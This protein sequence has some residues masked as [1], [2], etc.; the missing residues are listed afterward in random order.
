MVTAWFGALS[1]GITL[2]LLG[3]GGSI[4]TVP[5]LVYL[6]GQPDKVA[7]AGSLA[8]VGGISLFGALPYAL[9]NQVDWR[10]VLLFGVPGMIGSFAGAYLAQFVSGS[11]Q[12]LL[13]ALIMILAAFFMFR[14]NGAMARAGTGSHA[15]WKIGAEGLVVG[16]VTGLVGV[17]G[18]F[19]IVPALALLGGLSMPIAVG[20]SLLIIALKSFVGFMEYLQVLGAI[21]LHLDWGVIALFI[22]LGAVGSL[23]GKLVGGRISQMA[24]QRMFAAF[25]LVVGVFVL[26]QNFPLVA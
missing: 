7:I 15:W 25:L 11:L 18:G 22:C 6:L 26:W 3:S 19:L 4:L 9:K 2:G 1:I 8:I 21:D 14:G 10:S 24:L 16:I 13:F 5:I 12:M 23:L 17:G 20:T